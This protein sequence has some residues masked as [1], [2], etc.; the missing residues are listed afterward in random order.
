M[1]FRLI[2]LA[3]ALIAFCACQQEEPWPGQEQ[4]RQKDIHDTDQ[5]REQRLQ[6]KDKAE[7][8]SSSLSN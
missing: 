4:Y 2:F 6:S 1:N 7:T 3:S 8:E 5:Y